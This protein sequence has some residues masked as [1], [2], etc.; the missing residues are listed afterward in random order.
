MSLA[1]DPNEDDVRIYVTKYGRV[2]NALLLLLRLQVGP[3]VG[4]LLVLVYFCSLP[5][6][7]D[8]V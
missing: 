1:A 5:G 4:P 8:G 6:S 3:C 2:L 7:L